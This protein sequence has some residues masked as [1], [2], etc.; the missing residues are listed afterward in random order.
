MRKSILIVEDNA[1][2]RRTL[3]NILLNIG[4]AADIAVDGEQAIEEIKIHNYQLILMDIG[5]PGKDGCEVTQFIR[6]WEK[7]HHLPPSYIA[8]QS[9]HLDADIEKKCMSVGMNICYPKPLSTEIITNL[10]KSACCIDKWYRLV[11]N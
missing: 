6:Q 4:E 11:D 5:L 10:I 2:V 9:S 3:K 8:A 7:E 1:I